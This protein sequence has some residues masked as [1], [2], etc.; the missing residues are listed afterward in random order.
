MGLGAKLSVWSGTP[1]VAAIWSVCQFMGTNTDGTP[2][3]ATFCMPDILYLMG[4]D[5][6]EFWDM[7]AMVW[8]KVHDA[9]H[10]LFLGD[11]FNLDLY[12]TI[13]VTHLQR[14]H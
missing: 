11:L 7:C 14:T 4:S 6:G 13:G 3:A 10:S 1:V 9:T 8:G 5:P 2:V 12:R